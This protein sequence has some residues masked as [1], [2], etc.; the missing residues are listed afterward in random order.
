MH[1]NLQIMKGSERPAAAQMDG[2]IRGE[3]RWLQHEGKEE[4]QQNWVTTGLCVCT[5]SF[6]LCS[7]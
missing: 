4:L 3:I 5:E 2:V 7:L 6:F 1:T